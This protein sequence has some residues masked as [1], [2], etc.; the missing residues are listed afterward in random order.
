MK[1]V[2]RY[3]VQGEILEI[4]LHWDEHSQK[5]VEDYAG[6]IQQPVFTPAGRPILLTIEDA[7]PHADRVDDDPA[8]ID[9]GSCR[10]YDQLPGS[11]LGVCC[12]EAMRKCAEN[13]K[14]G[15]REREETP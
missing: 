11:L 15:T 6:F 10:Y 14:T 1:K 5:Y 7:C 3:E 8:G 12:H 9:C 13:L 2:H 4:P